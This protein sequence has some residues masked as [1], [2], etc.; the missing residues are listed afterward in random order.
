M[1]QTDIPI[2]ERYTQP[3]KKRQNIFVL[4]KTS[5]DAWQRKIKMQ[6]G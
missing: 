1:K 6:I 3:L 2:W 5:Y 4:A